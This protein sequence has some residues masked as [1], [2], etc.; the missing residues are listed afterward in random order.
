MLTLSLCDSVLVT[1]RRHPDV[2][3]Y[4]LK[5]IFFFALDRVCSR[6]SPPSGLAH[7]FSI[8]VVVLWNRV[9]ADFFLKICVNIWCFGWAW[10]H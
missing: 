5:R 10:P 1:L 2:F 3:E 8:Y 4:L 6:L 7:L 9:D